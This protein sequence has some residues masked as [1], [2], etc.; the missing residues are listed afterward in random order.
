MND[1]VTAINR[2]PT[3]REQAEAEVCEELLERHKR[4][5]KQLLREKAGAEQVARG[6]DMKIADLEQRIA[7]GTA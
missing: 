5:M 7:D 2:S 4:E 1:K 3:L 6:I